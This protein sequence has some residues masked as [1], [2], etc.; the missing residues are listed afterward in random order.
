MA[1]EGIDPGRHIGQSVTLRGT[2]WTG[3]GG[4]M[5]SPDAGLPVYIYGLDSWSSELEGKPV[6]VTGIVRA[7][8]GGPPPSFGGLPAHGPDPDTLLLHDAKW[9][10]LGS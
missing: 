2:A 7:R 5:V 3:A 6:E 8:E 9:T 10:L 4:A 1:E